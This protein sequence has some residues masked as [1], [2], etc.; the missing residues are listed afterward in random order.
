MKKVCFIVSHL[1]S[2]SGDLID[3][4]NKNPRCMIHNSEYSY[5]NPADL[6][7]LYSAGHKCRDS[8]AIYGDHL[9]RNMSFSCKKLY[10]YCKFIYVIRPARASLNEIIFKNPKYEP[11]FAARYYSYRLKRICEMAKRTKDSILV[12]W[13]DLSSGIAFS[14]IED[15]LGLKEK[16]QTTHDQF[17][18]NNRDYFKENLISECE[19]SYERHYY[20]LN[21]L[22][23]RRAT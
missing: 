17:I 14:L 1:G 21:N 19:D 3:T 8:S 15:Y 20:Y 13:E 12:T 16:L 23:I 9:L 7:W 6:N 22:G 18:F 11:E 4:L 5:E 10:E 2:G